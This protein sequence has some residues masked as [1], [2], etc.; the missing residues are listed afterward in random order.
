MPLNF[1]ATA[2]AFGWSQK[3]GAVALFFDLRNF[4][5]RSQNRPADGRG[6]ADDNGSLRETVAA[7]TRLNRGSHRD[8][9]YLSGGHPLDFV[10]IEAVEPLDGTLVD[11]ES[12]LSA[13][14]VE[15]LDVRNENK[16]LSSPDLIDKT[17]RP[18]IGRY[19]RTCVSLDTRWGGVA[20]SVEHSIKVMDARRC[21]GGYISIKTSGV[22]LVAIQAANASVTSFRMYLQCMNL[23]GNELLVLCWGSE[24]SPTSIFHWS[25]AP[26]HCFLENQ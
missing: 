16:A 9:G 13:V 8:F 5:T 1:H 11:L 17:A 22:R 4:K 15:H 25:P 24:A 18:A 6:H 12:A 7:F 10:A 21:L 2:P 19:Q 23:F 3:T 26:D 14:C 20:R